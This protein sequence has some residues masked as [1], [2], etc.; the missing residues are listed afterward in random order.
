MVKLEF[1]QQEYVTKSYFQSAI[2][3]E[4]VLLLLC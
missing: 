3:M 4:T 2:Q 1:D